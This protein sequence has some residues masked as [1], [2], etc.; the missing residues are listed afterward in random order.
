MT[1]YFCSTSLLAFEVVSVPDFGHFN[2]HTVVFHSYFN[3][4]LQVLFFPPKQNKTKHQNS[5]KNSL[6]IDGKGSSITVT[7][8]IGKIVPTTFICCSP[9]PILFENVTVFGDR[10]FKLKGGPMDGP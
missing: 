6:I 2:T 4:H 10:V 8:V 5:N 7:D 9:N 3:F 1:A